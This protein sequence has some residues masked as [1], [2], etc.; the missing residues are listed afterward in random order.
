MEE[1]ELSLLNNMQQVRELE[2]AQSS[3]M[4]DIGKTQ[5]ER[6]KL[7]IDKDESLVEASNNV[8]TALNDLKAHIQEWKK[9][10]VISS[11][12]DGQVEYLAFLQ[13]HISVDQGME[14]FAI[15]AARNNI[16]GKMLIPVS[17]AGQVK[18]GQD[19]NVKLLT[20]PYQK[21]G[22]IK[23]RIQSVSHH[24]IHSSNNSKYD[25]MADDALMAYVSFPD[26]LKTNYG[27]ILPCES[28]TKGLADIVTRKYK[29]IERLFSNLRTNTSK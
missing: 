5:I 23:A 6:A 10:Y 17:G 21:Y 14:L 26:G 3:A 28:E 20:Y 2:N 1:R 25:G 15:K 19:V 16:L 11:P 18:A 7:K 8:E 9:T 27:I 29:L 24:L 12:V 4:A 13:E 22:F